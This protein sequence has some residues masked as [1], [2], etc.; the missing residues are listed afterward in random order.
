VEV[1]V[2][3]ARIGELKAELEIAKR[4]L[5]EFRDDF[6]VEFRDYLTALEAPLS[7]E[8]LDH[9]ST[10]ALVAALRSARGSFESNIGTPTCWWRLACAIAPQHDGVRRVPQRFVRTLEAED[11]AP[12]SLQS[13]RSGRLARRFAGSD[14]DSK[15]R[16]V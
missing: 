12:V 5:S 7:V 11:D 14:A 6:S 1:R 9:A 10:G 3:G 15:A 8:R 4:I 2:S 13:S 16:S